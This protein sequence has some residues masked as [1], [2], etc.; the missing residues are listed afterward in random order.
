MSHEFILRVEKQRKRPEELAELPEAADS[1]EE[2]DDDD[3]EEIS[4][5]TKIKTASGKFF[6]I[7]C[8][9]DV[10]AEYR[11]TEIEKFLQQ[12]NYL[13]EKELHSTLI[14]PSCPLLRSSC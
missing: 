11:V 4:L 9:Y 7:K 8:S 6:L 13:T 1:E 2:D 3:E 14:H 5:P 12:S 10:E